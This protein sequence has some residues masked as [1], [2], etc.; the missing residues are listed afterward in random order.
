MSFLKKFNDILKKFGTDAEQRSFSGTAP[1]DTVTKMD[2]GDVVIRG[3]DDKEVKALNET[4]S[5][6]GYK[7]PGLNL[8][9]LTDKLELYFDTDK[10]LFR[11]KQNNQELINYLRRDTKSIE[12]MV[13][14]AQA[15]GFEDTVKKLLVRKPGNVP[16]PEDVLVGLIAMINLGQELNK[17]ARQGRDA[18]D[19]VTKQNLHKNFSLLASV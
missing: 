2:S 5:A 9:S 19:L 12:Q 17:L 16:P 11:I 6:D 13:A 1:D 18:T 3:M 14:M 4:L 8:I 7:G 10:L 15:S